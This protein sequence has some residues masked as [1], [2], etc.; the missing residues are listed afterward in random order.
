MLPWPSPALPGL[1][2]CW[3]SLGQGVGLLP[4]SQSKSQSLTGKRREKQGPA[5]I[6]SPLPPEMAKAAEEPGAAKICLWRYSHLVLLLLF[7]PARGVFPP[8]KMWP[9]TSSLR[10]TFYNGKHFKN[11][12]ATGQAAPLGLSPGVDEQ[13]L[14]GPEVFIETRRADLLCI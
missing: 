4:P 11:T 2:K 8:D 6:T 5:R 7:S 10:E 1:G 12:T 3:G 13:P 14:H 9:L